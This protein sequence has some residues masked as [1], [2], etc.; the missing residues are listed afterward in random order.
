MKPGNSF[1]GAHFPVTSSTLS[2]VPPFL[3][4]QAYVL[5]PLK[6][7]LMRQQAGTEGDSVQNRKPRQVLP[8]FSSRQITWQ[9]S[10]ETTIEVSI[11]FPGPV[12]A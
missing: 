7:N 8:Y 3:K 10:L 12:K 4:L 6:I 2:Q 1:P 9:F 11:L 5:P